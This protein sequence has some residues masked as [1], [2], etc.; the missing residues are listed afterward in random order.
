MLFFIYFGLFRQRYPVN[1]APFCLDRGREKD[2]L[3]ES[4][5]AFEGS[6]A[7]SSGLVNLEPAIPSARLLRLCSKPILATCSA[8]SAKIL[9]D[10]SSPRERQQRR[11]WL[12]KRHLESEFAPLQTLSR[13]SHRVQFVKCWWTFLELNSKGL[14]RRSRKEKESRCL[15]FTS[16]QREIRHLHVIVMQK[17]QRNVPKKTWCTCKFVVLLIEPIALLPF[18]LPSSS[19]L[20]KLRKIEQGKRSFC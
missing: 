18:S 4:C 10:S 6:T 11:H 12:Q 7:Q 9:L 13:L 8:C 3:P 14:Y 19:S 2:A 17:R 1:R 15:V 16:C 20:L 5:Q